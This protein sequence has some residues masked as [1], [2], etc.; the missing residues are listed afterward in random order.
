MSGNCRVIL[1]PV[2][3]GRKLP[4]IL[5]Q[6]QDERILLIPPTPNWG[7]PIRSSFNDVQDERKKMPGRAGPFP[8]AGLNIAAGRRDVKET[9]G[10][11]SKGRRLMQCRLAP[12]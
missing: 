4:V 6:V 5:Q 12:Q 11:M 3:D 1:Q 10:G 9:G 8:A 2:Q 7:R